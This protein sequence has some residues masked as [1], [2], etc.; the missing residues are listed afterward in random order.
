MSDSLVFVHS[1]SNELHIV[2]PDAIPHSDDLS[3]IMHLAGEVIKAGHK[4]VAIDGKRS[5]DYALPR[6]V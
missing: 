3:P 1:R 4:G 2:D 6:E 5:F